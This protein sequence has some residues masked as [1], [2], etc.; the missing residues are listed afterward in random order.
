MEL[1]RDG[2]ITLLQSAVLSAALHKYV[3]S[4][5]PN[6]TRIPD[7]VSENAVHNFLLR[8]VPPLPHLIPR[9]KGLGIVD[10]ETLF[11]A[12]RLEGRDARL[13]RLGVKGIITPLEARLI[14]EAMAGLTRGQTSV[15]QT[16]ES[17]PT[18]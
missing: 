11:A 1:V 2:K 3:K 10:E 15:Q 18:V 4:G 8:I 14:G 7:F 13:K 16:S 9:F 6:P 12:A 5:G 17:I